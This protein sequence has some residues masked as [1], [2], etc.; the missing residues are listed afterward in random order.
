MVSV[1]QFIHDEHLHDRT[2]DYGERKLTVY[3]HEFRNDR[4]RDDIEF[5]FANRPDES[6]NLLAGGGTLKDAQTRVQT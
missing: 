5:R 2:G 3:R 6:N 4:E 1:D